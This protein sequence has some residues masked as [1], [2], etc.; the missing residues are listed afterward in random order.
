[1]IGT[2]RLNLLILAAGFAVAGGFALTAEKAV[3]DTR[4]DRL[5]QSSSRADA[6]DCCD[7]LVKDKTYNFQLAAGENC[8]SPGVV[9]CRGGD[10][11]GPAALTHG[12]A[13]SEKRCWV[14]TRGRKEYEDKGGGGDSQK[15]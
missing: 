5:C 8:R 13:A 6:R 11:N 9:I 4:G 1:M 10:A 12:V 2:S 14:Q 3:A 7:R 15:R